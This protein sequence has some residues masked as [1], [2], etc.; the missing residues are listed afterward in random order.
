MRAF[1]TIATLFLLVCCDAVVAF[2]HSVLGDRSQSALWAKK[3]AKN[4][5]K[6]TA[7]TSKGF[8]V[9]PP[10]FAQVVAGFPTRL[11]SKD[12]FSTISCPCGSTKIY[13]DC[14][15]TF[16]NGESFPQSAQ[17]VLQSRY[18]AFSFRLPAYIIET[19][20]PEC[21]DYQDDKISWAK[22]LH[23]GGM[24]D[25]YDFSGLEFGETERGATDTESFLEFKV[26]LKANSKTGKYLEG[27]EVVIAERSR[28]L[29]DDV[30]CKYAGGDVRTNVKGIEDVVLN[31]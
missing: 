18:A 28:F 21:R 29:M 25:S 17:A 22:S 20:H 31:S 16:H 24:F 2:T 13:A 10:T 4:K 3:S 26:R 27:E 1:T 6:Q 5:K 15:S 8:G 23:K 19:T 11:P 9:A 30:G 12:E 7:T 14:C